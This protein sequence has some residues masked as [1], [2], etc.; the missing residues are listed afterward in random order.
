MYISL[1]SLLKD[2]TG[3]FLAAFLDGIILDIKVRT[4]LNTVNKIIYFNDKLALNSGTFNTLPTTLLTG[5]FIVIAIITPIIPDI[6]PINP[7]SVKNILAISFLLA[8]I[9]RRIPIS[10]L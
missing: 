3:F 2:S 8:P 9:A 4:I 1:Y 10:Y 5:I 6:K 7:A